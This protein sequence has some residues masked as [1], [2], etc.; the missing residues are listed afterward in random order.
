MV[1]VHYHSDHPGLAV[2]PIEI[3]PLDMAVNLL[4]CDESDAA[5]L[6]RRRAIAKLATAPQ[7]AVSDRIAELA[8]PA[9]V[10]AIKALVASLAGLPKPAIEAAV[11][12]YIFAKYGAVWGCYPTYPVTTVT[13]GKDDT[14]HAQT[15]FD[16]SR[17]VSSLKSVWDPQMWETCSSY[18]AHSHVQDT[19]SVPSPTDCSSAKPPRASA[20]PAPGTTWADNMFEEFTFSWTNSWFQNVLG[21]QTFLYNFGSGQIYFYSYALPQSVCSQVG[22]GAPQDGGVEVDNGYSYIW[23]AG[24]PY[25]TSTITTKNVRFSGREASGLQ[26]PISKTTMNDYAEVLLGA[27]GGEASTMACCTRKSPSAK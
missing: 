12:N 26:L 11:Y 9:D 8:V 1:S 20:P 25:W 21:I 15:T 18:F 16:V 13:R 17:S 10:N 19:T 4:R 24:S 2:A 5:E 6:R 23:P 14:V 27:M 22:W 7:L 3:M